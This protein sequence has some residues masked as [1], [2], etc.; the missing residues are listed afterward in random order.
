M[1]ITRFACNMLIVIGSSGLIGLGF[2]PLLA[3]S[4]ETF[5]APAITL[6]L[7]VMLSALVAVGIVGRLILRGRK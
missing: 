5:G 6:F 2:V 3:W 7:V 4:Y 1:K